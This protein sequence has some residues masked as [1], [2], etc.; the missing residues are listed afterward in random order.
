M[1]DYNQTNKI[2]IS[3]N[4]CKKPA[5]TLELV[6]SAD[7]DGNTPAIHIN[8]FIGEITAQG[9][10]SNRLTNLLLAR[11][12]ELAETNLSVLHSID[13]DI[14]G[15]ICRECVVAYCRNCWRNVITRFDEGFYDDVRATCPN[16]HEQMIQD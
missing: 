3:C 2:D 9:L 1:N 10:G 4:R 13:Q 15:F 16:G 6:P 8:G 5:A 14:F 11:I 12:Q 7:S